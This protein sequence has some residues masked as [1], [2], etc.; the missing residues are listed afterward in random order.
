MVSYM[1]N[2]LNLTKLLVQL[3][4]KFAIDEIIFSTLSATEDVQ[5]S[6]GFTHE[7]LDQGIVVD[8]VTR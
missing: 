3:E 8:H 2:E 5:L 7:C 6:G 4:G 1:F